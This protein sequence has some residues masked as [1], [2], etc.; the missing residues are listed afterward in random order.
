MP[1]TAEEYTEMAAIASEIGDEQAELEALEGLES[2]GA[3]GAPSAVAQQ[4][5]T[6]QTLPNQQDQGLIQDIEA[7][8]QQIPGAPQISEL[9]A[10]A[11]RSVFDVI[12]FI[13]PDT[14]NAAL[15]V[16][17]SERR[18]PTLRESLGSEGGFVEPGTQRDVLR[19][20][21]Q[22]APLALGAGTAI[23]SAAQSL[24]KIAPGAESVGAGLLRQAA[25]GTTAGDVGLSAVAATGAEFGREEIGGTGGAIIGSIL[26]P[27]AL[28][29]GAGLSRLGAEGFK[30][31]STSLSTLSDDGASK[32]LAEA[33]VREGMSPGC[34]LMM[35][36]SG[37]QSLAQRRYRQMLAAT[38][39]VCL[40]PHLIRFRE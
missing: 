15:N 9:A 19:A 11:N 31:L 4:L 32:L 21:G 18:V 12:D 17:G 34:L 13:G 29:T 20:V 30:R 26:A 10:A 35:L 5:P 28:L 37:L 1:L 25:A 2:L 7:A 24:P 27:T 16:I 33:M 3:F 39:L 22:A 40:G 38:S 8:F 36:Q 14:V 23:R 6:Q